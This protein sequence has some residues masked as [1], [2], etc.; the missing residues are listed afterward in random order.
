MKN[1]HENQEYLSENI[2]RKQGEGGVE[3]GKKQ[4]HKIWVTGRICLSLMYVIVEK[5]KNRCYRLGKMV[6][7]DES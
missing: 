3:E 4:I 1:I 2:K 7:S 6:E 5:I